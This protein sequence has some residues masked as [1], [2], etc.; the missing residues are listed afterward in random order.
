[1]FYKMCPI[2]FNDD[3]SQL[4]EDI[5]LLILLTMQYADRSSIVSIPIMLMLCSSSFGRNEAE[6]VSMNTSGRK[7]E[8]TVKRF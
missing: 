4:H 5:Q 7:I 8:T 2:Y 3:S 6:E 1:M